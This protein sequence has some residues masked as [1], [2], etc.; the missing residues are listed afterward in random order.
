MAKKLFIGNLAWAVT[1]DKLKDA[2]AS[3][4]EVVAAR[5]VTERSSGRSKGFGFVEYANDA[6]AEKAKEEMNGKDLEGRAIRVEF[7][8]E[9]S[10]R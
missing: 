1:D 4:G 2:F 8:Q 7:A 3:F 6:D 9:P 5:V 10:V